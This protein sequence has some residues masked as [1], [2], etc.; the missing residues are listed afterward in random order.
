MRPSGMPVQ[1]AMTWATA[2]PSTL[3]CSS[4]RSPCSATSLAWSASKSAFKCSRSAGSAIGFEPIAHLAHA[5]H[6]LLFT[7][8]ALLE[9]LELELGARPIG[10]QARK[11]RRVIGPRGA[12]AL[13]DA[14][15]SGTQLDA[16]AAVFEFRGHGVLAH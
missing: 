12:F 2:C 7:R 15:F 13:E 8:P 6:D 11:I 1:L 4:G 5:R 14:D 3:T 16:P 10:A 9:F